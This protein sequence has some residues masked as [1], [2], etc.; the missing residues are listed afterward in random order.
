MFNLIA[1]YVNFSRHFSRIVIHHKE[2]YID[3]AS[4]P[5]GKSTLKNDWMR[6]ERKV[7]PS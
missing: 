3:I 5:V 1:K 2:T 6:R 4:Y 7:L